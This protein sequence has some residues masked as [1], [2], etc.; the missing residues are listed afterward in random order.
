MSVIAIEAADMTAEAAAD[1]VMHT[2]QMEGQE[3]IAECLSD[4]I[5]PLLAEWKTQL[6]VLTT[7]MGAG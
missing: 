3:A 1:K 5:M 2:Q 7:P 4:E 6:P